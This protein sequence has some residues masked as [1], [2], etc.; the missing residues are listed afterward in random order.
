MLDKIKSLFGKKESVVTDSEVLPEQ[1]FQ[2]EEL[3]SP[4]KGELKLLSQVSDQAF[5]FMGEGIA[6]EP[7]EGKVFSPV[8]GMVANVPKSKHS[9]LLIS[10][11][12]AE[13]LIHVGIDTVR[14]KGEH[15]HVHVSVGQ[16]VSCG[17]VL[18]DFD[19]SSIKDSGYEVITPVVVTNSSMYKSIEK[20]DKGP[21]STGDSIMKLNI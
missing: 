12:G 17:D 7:I 10:K 4:M 3:V 9:I 19:I 5:G 13:V 21:I 16:Q 8:Q 1:Q 14:L 20:V 6:I 15:F 11:N 2:P 18:M